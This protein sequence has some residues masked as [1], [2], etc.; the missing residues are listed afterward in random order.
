MPKPVAL[1]TVRWRRA[2]AQCGELAANIRQVRNSPMQR[3]AIRRILNKLH[4][5]A[6]YFKRRH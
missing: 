3:E 6:L 1:H 2:A 5:I 4:W